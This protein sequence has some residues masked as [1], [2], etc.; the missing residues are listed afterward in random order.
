MYGRCAAADC[1]A[2]A[3]SAD[4]ADAAAVPTGAA[5]APA[6]AAEELLDEVELAAA[7]TSTASSDASMATGIPAHDGNVAGVRGK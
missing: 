4:K 1:A 3:L 5:A 2:W 6:A 7:V